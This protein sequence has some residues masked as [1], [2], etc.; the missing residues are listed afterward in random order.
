MEALFTSLG[1]GAR[2]RERVLA[3]LDD[4]ARIGRRRAVDVHVMTFAFTDAAIAGR[5]IELARTRPRVTV[6][7]IADWSQ[8]AP[9]SGRQVGGVAGLDLAN[10]VVRY[11]K[12]Q[13]YVWDAGRERIRWSYRASRGLLHHKTLSVVV[14]GGPH[15]LVAGSFNWST[16]SANG[17]ENLLVLGAGEPAAVP[18]MTAVE[19]EFAAMW[20][21]GRVTLAPAEVG[22]HYAAIVEEYRRNPGA[23]PSA[24]VGRADAVDVPLPASAGGTPP[25][26]GAPAPALIA[27]SSRAAHEP[28]AQAGYAAEHRARRFDLHKPS[29]KVKRAPLTLTTLAL[30]TI[31]RAQAGDQLLVAMYGL[32]VRVPE[33]GALLDAARRGVRL[34][35]ILDGHV[36]AG[37]LVQLA[38]A[39]HREGLP[40]RLRAGSRTMHQKYVVHPESSTVLTGTA[41]LSTDAVRRHTEHR[42]AWFHDD[43]LTAAF[44]ADF[45]TMWR[46]LPPPFR[47]GVPPPALSPGPEAAAAR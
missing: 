46:R 16:R 44:V 6:R 12:D 15:T 26:G 24:I 20:T 14:D 42:L 31:S 22:A 38:T 33:Y 43:A 5:L 30:D 2:L 39:A 21:A 19:R 23:D 34:A 9:G 1:G 37:V 36:S 45:E 8:G 7:I 25:S 10:L 47:R 35:V 3:V 32:S 27:F 28:E 40:I 18:I 11:K 29:G 13:P 17:Y 4:A 41:N